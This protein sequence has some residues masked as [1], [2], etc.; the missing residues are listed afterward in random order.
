MP[1]IRIIAVPPGEAPLWVREKWVGLKLP[2]AIGKRA[3]QARSVG[4]LTAPKSF[5]AFLG[6]LFRGQTHVSAGY[7][8]RA[9]VAVEILESASPDA[10]KWWRENTPQL[11]ARDRLFI[12]RKETCELLSA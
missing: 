4:V 1:D 5:F 12:F 7:V 3:V 11:L 2:L 10:A 9:A 8:V 6:A